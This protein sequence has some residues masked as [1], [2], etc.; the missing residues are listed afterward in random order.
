LAKLAR[1]SHN[2]IDNI[3][4]VRAGRQELGGRAVEEMDGEEDEGA[5]Q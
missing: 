4:T 5:W 2:F 1:K 3:D